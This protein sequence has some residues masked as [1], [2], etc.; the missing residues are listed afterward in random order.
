MEPFP[1]AEYLHPWTLPSKFVCLPRSAKTT[2]DIRFRS[3][4]ARRGE[5]VGR[6]TELDKLSGEQ[7]RREI[8]DARGLLHVVGH[9]RDGGQILELDEQFFDLCRADGI[10]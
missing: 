9:D 7:K 4:I 6:R 5:Q 8:A 2:G 3:R 1:F 10:Q